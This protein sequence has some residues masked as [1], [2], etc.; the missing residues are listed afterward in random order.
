[1]SELQS[2]K[3][4]LE[5]LTEQLAIYKLVLDIGMTPSMNKLQAG[6]FLK[7]IKFL[8]KSDK[9]YV[10]VGKPSKKN[11]IGLLEIISSE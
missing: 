2:Q 10:A 4:Q 7:Q 1:M 11:Y 6:E 5:E 3:L 8:V 9:F